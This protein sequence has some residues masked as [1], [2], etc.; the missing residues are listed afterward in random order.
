M[1]RISP[2]HPR[3]LFRTVEVDGEPY[4]DG[5]YMGNPAIFPPIHNTDCADLVLVQINPLNRAAIPTTA[6][7][8]WNRVNEIR[9]E[10]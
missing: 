8:I 1:P 6:A 9:C 2:R 10:C 5:G 4:W 3:F 7:G